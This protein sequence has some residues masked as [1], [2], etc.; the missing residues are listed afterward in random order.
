RYRRRQVDMDAQQSRG[1]L[2][3]HRA[4]DRG[5][6]VAALGDVAGVPEALHQLCPR[7]RDVIGVPAGAGGPAR[8][9]VS[10]HRG[11]DDMEGVRRTPAMSG[12]VS[13]RADDLELFYDG[14]RPAMRDDDRQRVL[15][16]GPHVDEV[17]VDSVDRRARLRQGVE[18]R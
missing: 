10:R 3:R 8:K 4:G 12:R 15:M 16:S 2:A 6:P 14:S 7:S 17:N 1:R 9:A 11:Y 5:T 18:L 13:E